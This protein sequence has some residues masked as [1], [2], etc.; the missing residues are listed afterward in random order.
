MEF[1]FEALYPISCWSLDGATP[2][3]RNDTPLTRDPTASGEE[4]NDACKLHVDGV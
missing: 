3:A 4:A 1:C 2:P